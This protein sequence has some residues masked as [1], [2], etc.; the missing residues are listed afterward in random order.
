MIIRTLEYKF[1]ITLNNLKNIDTKNNKFEV[2]IELPSMSVIQLEESN[3]VPDNYIVNFVNK[4]TSEKLTQKYPIIKLW[5][6]SID[7]LVSSNKKMLLPFT[8]LKFRKEVKNGE[9]DIQSTINFKEHILQLQK[10]I[11]KFFKDDI[12]PIK[13]LDE[14]ATSINYI[15][16]YIYKK[17]IKKNNPLRKEVE[18]ML[19]GFVEKKYTFFSDELEREA[20][21]RGLKRGEEKGIQKGIQKERINSIKEAIKFKYPEEIIQNMITRAGI[22]KEQ[23]EKITKEVK[24]TENMDFQ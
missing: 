15:A 1:N 5:E 3:D 21:E 12:V 11:V 14:W 17:Y 13:T 22:S 19:K 20:E 2:N 10:N 4:D 24:E 9:L 6:Y 18:D 8:T 7:D 16:N 23:F